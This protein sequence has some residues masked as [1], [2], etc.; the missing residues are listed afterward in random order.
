MT[1]RASTSYV[2]TLDVNSAS[3]MEMLQ[4]IKKAVSVIN[5]RNPNKKRV[6]I[7]GRKPAVKMEIGKHYWTGKSRKGPVNFDWFGNIVG[8]I[9]NATKLDVYIYDRRD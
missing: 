3:D 4:T 8:G 7:R 2:T 1:K 9:T 5:F 6:V